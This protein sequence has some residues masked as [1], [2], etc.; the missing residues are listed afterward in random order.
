VVAAERA[1]EVDLMAGVMTR[2]KPSLLT[3]PATISSFWL[4]LAGAEPPICGTGMMVTV[5]WV[6]P[7]V[8]SA[9]AGCSSFG[10]MPVK[11]EPAGTACGE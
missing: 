6:W 4:I 2:P 1:I 10:P 11:A 8:G 3:L 9:F 7:S 5:G